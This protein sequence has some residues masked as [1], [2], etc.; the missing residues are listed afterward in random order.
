MKLDKDIKD[1]IELVK[2]SHRAKF[3]KKIYMFSNEILD[4]VAKVVDYA[5]KKILTVAASGDQYLSSVYYG[6]EDITIFDINS[7]AYYITILKIAAVKE[8]SYKEFILFFISSIGYEK[9]EMFL[10]KQ[11]LNKL[12]NKMPDEVFYYWDKVISQIEI[13]GLG[14]LF[15]LGKHNLSRLEKNSIYKEEII[16][17]ELQSKLKK[18]EYPE[19][20]NTSIIH[21]TQAK[22]G[23]YDFIYLSNILDWLYKASPFEPKSEGLYQNYL[24]LLLEN[25][26]YKMVEVGGQVLSYYDILCNSCHFPTEILGERHLISKSPFYIYTR[27]K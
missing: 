24:K 14:K 10:K 27:K 13:C 23:T 8:F 18:L 17:Y 26:I 11:L 6:A 15:Y 1:S 25:K 9:N 20:I 7:L 3:N 12:K 16:Y 4:D 5:N 19:F 21:F 22:Y 2:N